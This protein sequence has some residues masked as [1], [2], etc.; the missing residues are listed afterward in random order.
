MSPPTIGQMRTDRIPDVDHG[1]AARSPAGPPHFGTL[2]PVV[3]QVNWQRSN[4]TGWRS[5]IR[6][7]IFRRRW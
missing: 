6:A 4:T 3:L 1:T 2:R 5:R 7:E